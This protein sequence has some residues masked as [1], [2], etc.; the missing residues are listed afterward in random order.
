MYEFCSTWSIGM[1]DLFRPLRGSKVLYHFKQGVA[2]PY[3][4]LP[5]TGLIL[6]QHDLEY[7]VMLEEEASR[8]IVL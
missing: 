7:M 3:S 6:M 2:L 4:I 8:G 5:L 1:I